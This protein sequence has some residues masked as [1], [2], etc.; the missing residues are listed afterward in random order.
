MKSLFGTDGIRGIAN[1]FLSPQIAYFLGQAVCLYLGNKILIGKDTRKSGDLLESSVAAGVMSVGGDVFD[2]DIIPTPGVSYLVQ[3]LNCDAG[4]VISASHNPPEY[5]GIKVFD[6]QGF[7][8]HHE[9]EEKIDAYIHNALSSPSNEIAPDLNASIPIGSEIGKIIPIENAADLYVRHVVKSITSQNID[10]SSLHVALDVGHGASFYTTPKALKDLGAKVTIINESYDGTDI[11]V[12]CGSTHLDP[13]F[14]LMDSSG[15]DI[16]IAHDGDADRV[17]LVTPDHDVIDGDFIAA[18]LAIDMKEN[19]TLRKNTVVST[20]MCNVGF[21]HAMRDAGIDVVQTNVGDK[22]VLREMQEHDYLLGAEQSGHVIML[23]HNTTGDG[24]M[25][26]CQYLA[27]LV[28]KNLTAAKAFSVMQR[29]PQVLI[30]VHSEY[31]HAYK[32]DPSIVASIKKIEDQLGDEGRVL[33]R[34][35]GTEPLVRVMVEAFSAEIAMNY[36]KELVSIIQ[37]HERQISQ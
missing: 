19:D 18:L 22:Y 6:A 5:N 15:A 29:Y 27:V 24:L 7:K 8:I 10:F 25:T 12:N 2:A 14:D 26:A 21:M 32:D 16:G 13:L 3:H 11:N 28:K 17:M 4:V 35:S 30:N 37:S 20:V 31:K 23:Q 9:L 1:K 34:P 36:A 33:V